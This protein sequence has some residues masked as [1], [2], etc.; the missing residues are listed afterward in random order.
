MGYGELVY[1]V[2]RFSSSII[3]N[4][5]PRGQSPLY[6]KKDM[7]R[8]YLMFKPEKYFYPCFTIPQKFLEAMTGLI[9]H[10]YIIAR[11]SSWYLST[12]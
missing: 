6:L 1:Q 5:L 2:Y 11:Y 10:C 4:V 9:S 7:L 12:I 8:S 3:R